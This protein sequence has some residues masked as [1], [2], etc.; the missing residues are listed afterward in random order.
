VARADYIDLE[1]VSGKR[2]DD[3]TAVTRDLKAFRVLRAVRLLKL[4][5]LLKSSR[6]L[7]RWE[8]SYSINYHLMD[9]IAIFVKVL[10]V[11]HIF[12]CRT[13]PH[14]H[15][16]HT[17]THTLHTLHTLTLIHTGTHVLHA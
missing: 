1:M 5:R 11:V 13:H 7:R 8:V 2:T 3:D 10:F 15:P 4:M 9:I 17:L 16:L 14:P 12:A 6:L